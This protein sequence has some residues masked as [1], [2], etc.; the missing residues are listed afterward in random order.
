MQRQC[1]RAHVNV[2][3]QA[4]PIAIVELIIRT[5]PYVPYLCRKSNESNQARQPHMAPRFFP[6]AHDLRHAIIMAYHSSWIYVTFSSSSVL[7]SII[8][9]RDRNLLYQDLPF[10]L[11]PS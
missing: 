11:D 2:M 3:L 7:V 6:L 1:W 10:T 4:Q 5:K 8:L 9:L